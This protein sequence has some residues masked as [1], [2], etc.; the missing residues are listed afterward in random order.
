MI[1][2]KNDT[3]DIDQI[4]HYMDLIENDEKFNTYKL[5]DDIPEIQIVPPCGVLILYLEQYDRNEELLKLLETTVDRKA[6]YS[7][8]YIQSD[9]LPFGN[10]RSKLKKKKRTTLISTYLSTYPLLCNSNNTFT[11]YIYIVAKD[12]HHSAL[13]FYSAPD[14]DYL[15]LAASSIIYDT[16]GIFKSQIKQL[17]YPALS[18]YNYKHII[19]T[20]LYFPKDSY[21]SHAK[22]IYRL[23][24]INVILINYYLTT[25]RTKYCKRFLYYEHVIR[26]LRTQPPSNYDIEPENAELYETQE[27]CITGGPL[28]GYFMEYN[29]KYMK[30]KK[31]IS[32]TVYVNDMA[33]RNDVSRGV[34]VEILYKNINI[35]T[36]TKAIESICKAKLGIKKISIVY[37]KHHYIN[38]FRKIICS[39]DA[40][41]NYKNLLHG[42]LDFGIFCTKYRMYRVVNI[43]TNQLFLGMDQIYDIDIIKKM[44]SS[45][46]LFRVDTS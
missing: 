43:R 7:Y 33:L 16:C 2:L 28:F 10:M 18:H 45:T 44:G 9:I 38:N 40:E 17:D 35:T 12:C 32:E 19:Y 39:L 41:Q 31:N 22:S 42:I 13:E 46:V 34:Y 24:L 15:L 29:I 26:I 25:N 1:L 20:P 11:W 27:C 4:R 30:G 21:Y 3:I 36:I 23:N 8:R 14:T 6:N 5:S 37:V